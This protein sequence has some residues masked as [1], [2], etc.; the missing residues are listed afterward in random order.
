AR[1]RTRGGRRR[2][3]LGRHG[4]PFR[5]PR[6]RTGGRRCRRACRRLCAR[7][8]APRVSATPGRRAS[9]RRVSRALWAIRTGGRRRRRAGFLLVLQ[10]P[11]LAVDVHAVAPREAAERDTAVAA[12]LDGERR[13]RSDGDDDWTAGDRGF[14]DELEREATADAE[15][16]VRERERVVRVCPAADLVH[17]V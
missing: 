3:P 16:L 10:P 9:R 1:S 7:R 4:G 11:R 15:D 13:R 17:R 2:R 8:T 12:K 5:R 14:L 6:A